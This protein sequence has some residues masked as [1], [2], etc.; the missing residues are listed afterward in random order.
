MSRIAA[1]LAALMLTAPAMAQIYKCP[2]AD[3]RTVIQQQ[4]CAGG[5][6]LDVRPASG[7]AQPQAATRGD[8]GDEMA[9]PM[10]N[11]QRIEANTQASQR[12]RERR[13]L[14]Q[15]RVPRARA[16]IYRWRDT[17]AADLAA[18]RR[19][20]FAYVQNLYGKTH[21]AQRA[22]EQ[23]ALAATC[24]TEDRALVN[25]YNVLLQQC[26]TLGGCAGMTR[27]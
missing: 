10:T 14:E 17:C 3:G 24:D 9:P 6:T 27:E 7:P 15:R 8:D 25:N 1:A 2:D 13:A 22:S 11:A 21:A 23:A 20:E 16:A 12:E 26:T 5:K 4:P 19:D 18:L